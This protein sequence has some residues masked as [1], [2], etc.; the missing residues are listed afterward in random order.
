MQREVLLDNDVASVWYYA[1]ENIIHHK[2]H[3]FTYGETFQ[4]VLMTGL[5]YFE[6]KGCKKWLSDDRNNSALRKSDIEW[7][8]KN[9]KPRMMNAGWKLWA[10]MMPDKVVG[11]MT[12]RPLIEEYSKFG[13]I[14]KIFDDEDKAFEWL[15]NN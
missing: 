7:G 5:K 10:L 8:D 13:V 4:K 2:F 12:L 3:K 6:E 11:Q 14:V 1:D 15:K 9:W